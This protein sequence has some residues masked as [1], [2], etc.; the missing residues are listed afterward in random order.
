MEVQIAGK[1]IAIAVNCFARVNPHE[2]FKLFVPYLCDTIERL[3]NEN[4]NIKDE[5]HLDAE[6][7]YNLLI[8]SEVNYFTL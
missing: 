1:M 8:L 2:T 6:L 3:L 4:T 7:L 5:E